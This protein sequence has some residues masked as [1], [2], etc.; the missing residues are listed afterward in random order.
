MKRTH[1]AVSGHHA[2][3]SVEQPHRADPEAPW[4]QPLMHPLRSV[5]QA[6]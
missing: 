3:L 5:N 4:T 1:P 2:P 6:P